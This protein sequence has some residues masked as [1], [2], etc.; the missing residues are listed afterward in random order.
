MQICI[1]LLQA[2]ERIRAV[3]LFHEKVP[4]TRGNGGIENL[5]DW[6]IAIAELSICALRHRRDIVVTGRPS[7]L[8]AL[9]EE[10]RAVAVEFARPH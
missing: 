10:V 8:K 3:V 6:Q 2:G 4:S 1:A 9:L 5:R 7:D